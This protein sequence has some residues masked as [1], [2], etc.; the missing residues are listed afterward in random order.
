[1]E[2]EIFPVRGLPI[3][4]HSWGT[5][6]RPKV[7][8]HHGFLDHGASFAA[9]AERLADTYH[10]LAMDARGHG[11]S[12]WVG[13]GG[14]YHF[15]DFWHDL[16]VV[17]KVHGP[18]RLVGHSM[19]GMIATSVAAARPAMVETLVLLDGM[20]PPE[21]PIEAWPARLVA[22]LDALQVPGY[23]GDVEERRASRRTMATVDEAAARLHKANHRLTAEMALRLA[24]TSTEPVPGGVVWRHDPLHRTPSARPFRADEA[25]TLFAQL[26]MPVLSIY[27]AQSEWLPPD[28]PTRHAAVPHLHAGVLPDAGHNLHHEQPERLAE[29]LRSWFHAP[30]QHLP[31]GLRAGEPGRT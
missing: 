13:A 30:G 31:D 8:F 29:M 19:G 28:L 22:W 9:I 15:A 1:M 18:V 6:G 24:A 12:G 2:T 25:R 17:L 11:Q 27:A 14:Y 16:D 26:A 3:A 10:V 20:G 7:L 4:V 23:T 5:P 21:L